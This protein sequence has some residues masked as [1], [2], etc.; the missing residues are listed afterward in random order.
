[1]PL[2][3]SLLPRC[4]SKWTRESGSASCTLLCNWKQETKYLVMTFHTGRQKS[5][6]LAN[7][8][9]GY[10]SQQN[11][12]QS[13]RTWNLWVLAIIFSAIRILAHLGISLN[14]TYSVRLFLLSGCLLLK[15]SIQYWHCTNVPICTT[16]GRSLLQTLLESTSGYKEITV[17]QIMDNFFAICNVI[18]NIFN[19]TKMHVNAYTCTQNWYLWNFCLINGHIHF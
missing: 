18:F 3:L 4:A 16:C 5:W 19:R 11:K 8:L 9:L 13:T 6:I 15:I 2:H 12:K 14:F 1:M 7:R 17:T 10:D